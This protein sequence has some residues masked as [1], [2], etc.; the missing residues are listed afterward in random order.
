VHPRF[1]AVTPSKQNDET[2]LSRAGFFCVPNEIRTL[3][4]DTISAENKP[5]RE[6]NA[7]TESDLTD[8]NHVAEFVDDTGKDDSER[9]LMIALERASAAG[10]WDIVRQLGEELQ[11]RRLARLG[12]VVSLDSKRSGRS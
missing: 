6:T 3:L 9:A 12:N 4:D 1:R 11:A 7:S 8:R 10:Q 5:I 2:R